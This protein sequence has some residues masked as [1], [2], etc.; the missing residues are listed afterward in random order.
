[1]LKNGWIVSFPYKKGNPRFE[2]RGKISC[3]EGKYLTFVAERF[4]CTHTREFDEIE[5]E[6][7]GFRERE[8]E[9]DLW[10]WRERSQSLGFYMWARTIR[11]F[12][13]HMSF[14]LDAFHKSNLWCVPS[15][16]ECCFVLDGL[17]F[18]LIMYRIFIQWNYSLFFY[19]IFFSFLLLWLHSHTI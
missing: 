16:C 7:M 10:I 13:R 4:Y 5:A 12:S 1:M 11:T 8:W 17:C 14:Q 18:L 15:K 6:E 2:E 19:F 9:R 3:F